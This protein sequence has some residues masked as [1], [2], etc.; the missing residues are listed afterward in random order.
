MKI[1]HYHNLQTK[2]T[3]CINIE[4][5]VTYFQKIL[6][7]ACYNDVNVVLA[8]TKAVFTLRTTSY[9]VVRCRPMSYVYGNLR[10]YAVCWPMRMA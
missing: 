4:L 1:N 10:L 2:L 7:T 9:D 8:E 6:K 5:A 3:S